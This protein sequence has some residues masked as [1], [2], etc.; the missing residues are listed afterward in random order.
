MDQF[1][2]QAGLDRRLGDARVL[3]AWHAALGPDLAARARAVRFRAGE[4]T[5]EVQSAAH[6]QELASFTGED[7]RR[8]ANQR[9]GA[10]T[11]RRVSFRLKQ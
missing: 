7:F 4:L 6:R 1:L 8:A 5:V 3:S 10:E 2:R 9:L 11:I